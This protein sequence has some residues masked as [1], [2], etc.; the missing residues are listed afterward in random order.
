MQKHKKKMEWVG[1]AKNMKKL[2]WVE[3]IKTRKKWS[4]EDLQK[5]NDEVGRNHIT[6]TT[7]K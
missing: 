1:I 2:G 7:K 5:K 6:N 3:I 4:R